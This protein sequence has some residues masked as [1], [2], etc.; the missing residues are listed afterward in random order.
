MHATYFK[1]HIFPPQN[2]REM[3]E[4]SENEYNSE[5]SIFSLSISV[6]AL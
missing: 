1:K 5:L 2:F 3:E 4:I 6:M